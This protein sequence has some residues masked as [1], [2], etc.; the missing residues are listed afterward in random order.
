MA[1]AFTWH[2]YKQNG[3]LQMSSPLTVPQRCNAGELYPISEKDPEVCVVAL[4]LSPSQMFGIHVRPRP[5]H[6]EVSCVWQ[7]YPKTC[8]VPTVRIQSLTSNFW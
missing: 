2:S 3:I 8:L 4:I 1:E 7:T 6:F 5:H